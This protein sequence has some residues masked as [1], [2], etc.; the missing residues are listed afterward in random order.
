MSRPQNQARTQQSR[1][2]ET[3][4][5]ILAAAADSFAQSGLAGSVRI[6]RGVLLGGQA[7]IAD[8]VS[9]G[10]AARVAAKS[11]VIGDVP[12]GAV[13][14]GYPAL[15]RVRWLRMLARMDRARRDKDPR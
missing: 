14:A 5:A 11:G 7:G 3:R 1:S 15:P 13:V 10:D 9:I 4:A 2:A 8:H 6:G 12:S